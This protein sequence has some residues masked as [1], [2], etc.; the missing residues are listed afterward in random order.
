MDILE[1]QAQH[2]HMV[3]DPI[4]PGTPSPLD[5]QPRSDCCLAP[6]MCVADEVYACLACGHLCS[7]GG[8]DP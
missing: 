6:L 7:D 5:D 8:S 2:I 3:P 4:R 1:Y